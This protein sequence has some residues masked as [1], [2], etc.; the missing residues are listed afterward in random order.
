M[1]LRKYHP[2]VQQIQSLIGEGCYQPFIFSDN[3]I[4]GICYSWITGDLVI[5]MDKVHDIAYLWES[6]NH[7]LIKLNGYITEEKWGNFIDCNLRQCN[8]YTSWIDCVLN[9]LDN[10]SDY[11]VIDTAANAGWFLYQFKERGA[12]QC[13]GYDLLNFS[14]VYDTINLLTGYDVSRTI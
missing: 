1:D 3:F 8:M 6:P 14:Q 11:S 9:L 2:S 7:P 4:S 12:G 10:P 5:A 13:I